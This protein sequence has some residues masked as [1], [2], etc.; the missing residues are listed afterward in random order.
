MAR[1]YELVARPVPRLETALRRIV[2]AFPGPDSLRTAHQLADCAPVAMRGQP[3]AV[4]D[5][6]KDF[7][8]WDRWGNRWIDWSSGVLI[9]NAG[10]GRKEIV[11]AIQNQAAHGLLTNY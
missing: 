5:R 2:T 6:A 8:V 10:H 11:E 1:Q 7:S 4:W 3:P 9:T